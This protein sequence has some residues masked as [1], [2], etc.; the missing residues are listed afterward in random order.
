M[1]IGSGLTRRFDAI[2]RHQFLRVGIIL[3]DAGGGDRFFLLNLGGDFEVQ[4]EEL[5]EQILL[6]A[7]AVGVE[8]GR[9]GCGSHFD[10]SSLAE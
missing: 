7:E 5:G 9:V 10:G 2:L 6:G 3:R 1:A 4:G 8:G